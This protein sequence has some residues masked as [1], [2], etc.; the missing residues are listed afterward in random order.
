MQIQYYQIVGKLKD[1]CKKFTKIQKKIVKIQ[2]LKNSKNH[3]NS[4]PH[5]H[6][7]T[8]YPF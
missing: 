4:K 2:I 7:T 5:M 3:T 8:I 1:Y 6:K